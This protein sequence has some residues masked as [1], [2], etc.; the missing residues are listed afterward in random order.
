MSSERYWYSIRGD[1]RVW[2]DNVFTVYKM[3]VV[4]FYA[5]PSFY[6]PPP[7]SGAKA[8]LEV[9]P[10]DLLLLE[11]FLMGISSKNISYYSHDIFIT[12]SQNKASQ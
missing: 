4:L 7:R 3:R 12:E 2:I 5:W 6:C 1:V 10:L 8:P 9:A 11:L